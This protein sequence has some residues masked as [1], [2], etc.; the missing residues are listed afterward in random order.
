MRS[1]EATCQSDLD[2]WEG[3]VEASRPDVAVHRAAERMRIGH[4]ATVK[5]KLIGTV[6]F[7]HVLIFNEKNEQDGSTQW[8]EHREHGLFKTAGE[9]YQ[10]ASTILK[11]HSESM[12][13]KVSTR[14]IRA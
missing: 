12:M 6:K 1:Y 2:H 11:I 3:T 9:A 14:R 8:V 10:Y 13:G 7:R 5:I 4:W